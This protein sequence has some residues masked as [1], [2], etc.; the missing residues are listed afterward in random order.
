MERDKPFTQEFYLVQHKET[1][2]FYTRASEENWTDEV[3]DALRFPRGEEAEAFRS[4]LCRR[5][6]EF[7]RTPDTLQVVQVEVTVKYLRFRWERL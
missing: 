3:L 2:K 4:E 1:E 6:E 5:Y 7:R